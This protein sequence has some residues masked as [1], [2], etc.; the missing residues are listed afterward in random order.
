MSYSR[1]CMRQQ[2][3]YYYEVV[4]TMADRAGSM[5]KCTNDDPRNLDLDDDDDGP[6]FPPVNDVYDDDEE[7]DN[8]DESVAVV[9]AADSA[10][11]VVRV[12]QSDLSIQS[13]SHIEP[14]SRERSSSAR[15]DSATS[16]EALVE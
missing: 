11:P 8:D 1:H 13:Q 9:A 2:F 15:T 4:D 5:P 14:H 12:G 16:T 10:V 3:N 6:D 7:E